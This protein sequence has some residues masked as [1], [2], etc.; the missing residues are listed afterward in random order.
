MWHVVE[1]RVVQCISATESPETIVK[2]HVP[3][4][5]VSSRLSLVL[6]LRLAGLEVLMW[7][8]LKV[9]PG[10]RVTPE[11]GEFDALTCEFAQVQEV[12]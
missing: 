8:T 2:G 7:A 5:R 11:L 9:V 1:D 3:D 6:S 12:Q 10:S 4:H